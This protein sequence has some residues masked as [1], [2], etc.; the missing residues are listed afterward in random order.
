[1]MQTTTY[2]WIPNQPVAS[3]ST[4]VSCE[5]LVHVHPLI[6]RPTRSLNTPV[7]NNRTRGSTT[8]GRSLQQRFTEGNHRQ[9]HPSNEEEF[10]FDSDTEHN[11]NT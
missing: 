11:N 9:R 5:P 8:R 3:T 6:N 4:N 7:R 2:E 1:M 10:V